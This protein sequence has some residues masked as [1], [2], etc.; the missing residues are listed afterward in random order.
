MDLPLESASEYHIPR[1]AAYGLAARVNLFFGNYEA[2][3]ENAE[4]ALKFNSK[5][6]DYDTLYFYDESNHTRV[7]PIALFPSIPQS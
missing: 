1:M 3:L 5:L 4:E 7:L 6:L 2:A